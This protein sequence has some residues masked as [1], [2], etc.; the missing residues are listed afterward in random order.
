MLFDLLQRKSCRIRWENGMQNHYIDSPR[1]PQRL[2]TKKDPAPVPIL[3]QSCQTDMISCRRSFPR[4][5]SIQ[6]VTM[7]RF[8]A[9]SLTLILIRSVIPGSQY[10]N[11]INLKKKE[12]TYYARCQFLP[13]GFWGTHQL[14]SSCRKLCIRSWPQLSKC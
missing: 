11:S 13:N 6:L 1:Q 7:L 4:D 9:L 3:L 2:M 14:A 5:S 10:R 12:R 8:S